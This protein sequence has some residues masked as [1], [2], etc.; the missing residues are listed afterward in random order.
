MSSLDNGNNRNDI[1]NS[2]ELLHGN[3]YIVSI[4]NFDFI[5]RRIEESFYF[6]S[7]FIEY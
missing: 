3:E 1:S 5:F 2:V 4:A 7:N 6:Y